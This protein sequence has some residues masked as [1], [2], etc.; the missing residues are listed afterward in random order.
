[1]IIILIFK[2]AWYD[3]YLSEVIKAGRPND[4]CPDGSY[5]GYTKA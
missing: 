2:A 4:N 5:D 1:M 3:S